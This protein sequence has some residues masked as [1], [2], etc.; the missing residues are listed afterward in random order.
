MA[1][2]REFFPFINWIISSIK[3]GNRGAVPVVLA[4]LIVSVVTA[5]LCVRRP[6]SPKA[7][8]NSFIIL[9]MLFILG[10]ALYRIRSIGSQMLA[11]FLGLPS[12]SVLLGLITGMAACKDKHE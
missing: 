12:L 5:V 11:A 10:E 2:V 3:Y 6:L 9:L 1:F 4:M 7:E 8:K